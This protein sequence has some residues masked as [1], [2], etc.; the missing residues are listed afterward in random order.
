M[1]AS[2]RAESDLRPSV[3][4]VGRTGSESSP[5]QIVPVDKTK[6]NRNH[7]NQAQQRGADLLPA[8]SPP[9]SLSRFP[10]ETAA[11]TPLFLGFGPPPTP[12]TAGFV[13]R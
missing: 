11:A 2:S 4:R 7:I 10:D 8:F 13:N 9:F 1:N 12:S 3:A 6:M 5:L